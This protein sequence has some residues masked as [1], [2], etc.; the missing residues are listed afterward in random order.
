MIWDTI[1]I[2]KAVRTH[3]SELLHPVHLVQV[4]FCVAECVCNSVMA[5]DAMTIVDDD[6]VVFVDVDVDGV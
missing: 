6:V 2:L 3:L 4:A 5:D 1:C